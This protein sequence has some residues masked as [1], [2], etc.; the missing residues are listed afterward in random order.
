MIN[1]IK[2]EFIP[3]TVCWVH[4]RGEAQ[5]KLAVYVSGSNWDS[6]GVHDRS[7]NGPLFTP[8]SVLV[9]TQILQP[10]MF[11]MVVA[12]G[13]YYSQSQNSTADQ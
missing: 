13:T 1:M 8:F 4:K 5:A 7:S 9:L 2:L 11:L 3:S 12:K 6:T 10:S